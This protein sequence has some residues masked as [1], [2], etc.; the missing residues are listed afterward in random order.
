MIQDIIIYIIN[1]LKGFEL[2]EYRF[3]LNRPILKNK[4]NQAK[5]LEWYK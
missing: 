4:F 1:I 3:K 2:Y 5:L